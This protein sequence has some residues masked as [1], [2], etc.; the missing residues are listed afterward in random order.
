MKKNSAPDNL[1]LCATAAIKAGMS[2]GKYMAKYGWNP[3]IMRPEPEKI[4]D[5]EKA[6][7]T[8]IDMICG[9]CGTA[10]R[11]S[12]KDQKYCS[13]AC[14]MKH[15]HDAANRRKRNKEAMEHE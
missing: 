13:S 1:T 4:G 12:R 15:S 3:P 7:G 9:H 8:G 6:V 14:Q 5:A 2:Y 11:Q 10:F